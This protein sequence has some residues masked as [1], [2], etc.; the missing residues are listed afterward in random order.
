MS[1]I[2][3]VAILVLALWTPYGFSLIGLIE[4]WGLVGAFT[5]HGLFFITD[6]TSPLAAH[7][8]RPLTIL[9]QA[10][11]YYLDPYSFKYWNILL[12]L[13]LC[14]KGSSLSYIT[15]YIT[16]SLKWGI[17]AS[18]L[19]IV[20]PADTMQLS[21]RALHI[22]WALSCLLL[23][24]A[25]LIAALQAKSRF[26][27]YLLS[28]ISAVLLL[29]ACAMYEASLLL[30]VLPFLAILI[31]SNVK[32]A[33][34]QLR[35][36]IW[37]HLIWLM[38][39]LYYI[40]YVIH[41][42]PLVNSYQSGIAGSTSVTTTLMHSLPNL[43]SIGLL[44][45][46]LGGWYDAFSITAVE[47]N[48]Y[49]YTIS[50][51]LIISIVFL[52][53]LS[54]F[55]KAKPVETIISMA[56][57]VKFLIAGILLVLLGYA[58][59]LL[60][61]SHQ[62]ISQRTFLFATPGGVFVTLSVLIGFGKASK[63]LATLCAALL[64]FIGLSTQLYQFHHYVK[65]SDRQR[66]IIK[67]IVE[68]FDGQIDDKTLVIVDKTSQL[69]NTWMFINENLKA[70]LNYIYG[71]PFNSIE[72][73]REDGNEWQ[74]TDSVGRKGTCEETVDEWI[75]HY[76]TPI[77]GPGFELTKQP[78]DKKL[79]KSKIVVITV[80]PDEKPK[81]NPVR[82]EKLR[83]EQ[84]RTGAIY[85]GFIEKPDYHNRL[86]GFNDQ[87]SGEY[88]FWGFGNW[89]SMELPIAGSGWREAE[90]TVNKFHHTASA[91]KTNKQAYL[92]FK[93]TPSSVRYRL[94][95]QFDTIVNPS[96]KTSMKIE[97]NGIDVPFQWNDAN[98]F[99][100]K[101]VKNQLRDGMN[102]IAFMSDA[103]ENYYGFSGRL[104]W[105]EIKK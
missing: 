100:A 33:V 68:N 95:G 28:T 47:F 32:A 98:Q 14:V 85:R 45:T 41:T 76:P 13:S 64:I 82:T 84:S 51:I 21:F 42:A 3:P 81:A 93:F 30:T 90:W 38:G 29:V 74:H 11:A 91:W 88:Y 67:N 52:L 101:L 2:L 55:R 9:P 57:P 77:S 54:N 7:A 103:D 36:H 104:D 46:V 15:S 78:E 63:N 43:F 39:A 5:T 72:V 8:L 70:T 97:V 44:R 80:D 40:A 73:C 71:H 59:F 83:S 19:I 105:V 26:L 31:K 18:L 62:A 6:T 92:N 94:I 17:I 50:A 12:A 96:V 61:T 75:F 87:E 79:T 1:H 34:S 27:P 35:Q 86:I 65:I 102:T 10:I 89:W 66:N 4:E 53:L 56:I 49:W 22:N 25:I 99:E 20:Y 69:N 37:K 58:P 60:S 48:T 23:G 24:T 16:G